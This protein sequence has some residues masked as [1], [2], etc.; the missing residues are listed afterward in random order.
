MNKEKLL[1]IFTKNPE[2]GKVKTRLAATIGNEK[3][4]EVYETLRCHTA[5]IAA[6]VDVNKKVFFSSFIPSS[7]IFLKGEITADL[8]RGTDL[9]KRMQH[10]I[11]IGFAIGARHI[12]LIGTDC[13]ELNSTI[14]EEAFTK[15]ER[16]DAV[17]GPAKDG[18]F[19]LIGMNKVIPELFLGREW[20]TPQVFRETIE[21]LKRLDISHELLA[22]LSDIDT[23]EDLKNSRLW[24]PE[25]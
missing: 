20:S 22:E 3:A 5:N 19:Y 13:Y 18:G 4:L 2:A 9:G 23:F 10:A 14:L 11:S 21:I 12:V 16:T 15:L 25:P 1:I 17:I 8:Q 7:D 6:H 24:N